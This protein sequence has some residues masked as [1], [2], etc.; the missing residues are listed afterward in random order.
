M[1]ATPAIPAVLDGRRALVTGGARGIGAAV[2]H[3]FAAAG[4]T[5]VVLDL[6]EGLDAA[7]LPTG[8]SALP[9][10]VC[11]EPSVAA[12]VAAA[13]D[14][15]GGLDTVVAAAGIVPA[16]TSTAETDLDDFDRVLAVNARG[17]AAT[18]KHVAPHLSAGASVVAVASLNSWRGDGNLT[19]Y[20]ASKHAVVGI[21]R[22]AALSLGPA[23]VRVN[24]VAP[25][26]IA[27]EALRARM[28]SRT[29]TTGLSVDEAVAA[30]GRGTALG[31]I[32][33]QAEVA[34]AILFLASDLAGGISGHL[35]P[36]DGGLGA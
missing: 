20:A 22:S 13:V 1:T 35:L 4:A 15:L 7:E 29:D 3:R 18:L 16:W 11:D 26:P 10:D 5:G 9:V 28:A 27:T 31:R 21:V 19:S 12:A 14:L 30:A 36:V 33:T 25:G 17:V 24:A 6:Q 8:W 2:A 23:G 32:A 34:D